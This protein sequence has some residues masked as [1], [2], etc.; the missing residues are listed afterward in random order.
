MQTLRVA[1]VNINKSCV[2]DCFIVR[3][4]EGFPFHKVSKVTASHLPPNGKSSVQT[5]CSEDLNLYIPHSSSYTTLKTRW[6]GV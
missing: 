4:P 5:C 6:S 1:F 2:N 3:T